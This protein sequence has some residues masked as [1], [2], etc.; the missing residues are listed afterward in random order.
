M[1]SQTRRRIRR[2]RQ[3]TIEQSIDTADKLYRSNATDSNY[4]RNSGHKMQRKAKRDGIDYGGHEQH[5]RMEMATNCSRHQ[6]KFGL[7]GR[8]KQYQ[9]ERM[10]GER[11][12]T[13]HI[14]IN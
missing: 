14:R 2:E 13:R 4:N 8:T 12:G 3:R 10:S 7:A 5:V 9:R 1:N 6:S 11:N